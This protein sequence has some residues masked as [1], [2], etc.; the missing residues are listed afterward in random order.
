MSLSKARE[1]SKINITKVASVSLHLVPSVLILVSCH[2]E[3]IHLLEHGNA[4][5]D[6]AGLV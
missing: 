4:G 6:I 3:V 5:A 2:L 1:N